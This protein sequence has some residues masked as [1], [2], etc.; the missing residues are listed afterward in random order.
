[1]V[2]L[3]RRLVLVAVLGRLSAMKSVADWREVKR[4]SGVYLLLLADEQEDTD[5]HEISFSSI[6]EALSF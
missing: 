4:W 6:C 5:E 3:A 1:M 2:Q